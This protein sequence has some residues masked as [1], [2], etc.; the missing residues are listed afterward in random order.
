[1]LRHPTPPRAAELGR[2]W[3]NVQLAAAANLPP[4]FSARAFLASLPRF[5][6]AIFDDRLGRSLLVGGLLLAGFL[7]TIRDG[8][9]LHDLGVYTGAAQGLMHGEQIYAS[10]AG[11]L[12]PYKYAPWFAVAWIPL[13]FLP[14]LLLD[15][16]WLSVLVS[17]TGWLLW[18][19]PWGLAIIAGPFVAWGA[20]IGNVAPLLFGLL[21]LAL[22]TRGAA[23]AIGAAAS[24]KAFPVM[25]VIPLIAQRRWRE[26]L[27]AVG[28]ALLLV[29]PMLLFDLSGYQTSPEGPHSVY[30][31]LGP[32]AWAVTTAAGLA[33]ALF[34]PSWR[35]GGLAV[36][37]TNP[38]FEWYDLGYLLIGQARRGRQDEGGADAR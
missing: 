38:R 31:L 13:T 17:A 35:S 23:V 30:N 6:T 1:M 10:H 25:L 2:L 12:V 24:L 34:R 15:L 16:L 8:Q 9:L 5:P 22:P 21:A 36:M 29:A 11:D 19:A 20:A 37:L 28:V 26:A 3:L 14:Q 18:R 27:L 4:V 32:I 7:P 33:I